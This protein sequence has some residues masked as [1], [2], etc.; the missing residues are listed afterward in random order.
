MTLPRPQSFDV[1]ALHRLAH[2]VGDNSFPHLFTSKYRLLLGERL[3]RVARTLQSSDLASALDAILSLK[4]SSATVGTRELAAL[5]LVIETD[6]RGHDLAAARLSATELEPVAA[7]A[8][9]ALDDYLG[10]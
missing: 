5:A 9:Q 3:A 4:V 1:T 2:E 7:R 6:L 8:S 10:G